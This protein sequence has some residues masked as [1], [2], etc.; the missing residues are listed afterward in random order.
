[1]RKRQFTWKPDRVFYRIFSEDTAETLLET[2]HTNLYNE[3]GDV[4]TPE[5][6]PIIAVNEAIFYMMN[7]ANTHHK[8]QLRNLNN[9]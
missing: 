6:M 8:E 4:S 1:M 2:H 7:S 3:H 5:L 9:G